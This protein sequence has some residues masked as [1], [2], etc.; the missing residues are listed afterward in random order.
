MKDY[1]WVGPEGSNKDCGL[2]KRGQ[3]LS[4]SSDKAKRLKELG[5]IEEK[6]VIKTSTKV[7]KE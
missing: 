5:F 3:V 2:V 7:D 4:L 6:K 1:I